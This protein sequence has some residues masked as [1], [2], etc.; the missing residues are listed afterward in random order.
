MNISSVH[1]KGL[2]EVVHRKI[3]ITPIFTGVMGVGIFWGDNDPRNK[4][5]TYTTCGTK[6]NR[7]TTSIAILLGIDYLLD[8]IK[9]S[10][11]IYCDNQSIIDI[12]HKY[13]CIAHTELAERIVKKWDQINSLVD[14]YKVTI[15]KIHIHNIWESPG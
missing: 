14:G 9:E 8:N 6:Q 1:I 10:T 13:N 7:C 15:D 3:G 11:H 4:S 5:L 12:I 2:C